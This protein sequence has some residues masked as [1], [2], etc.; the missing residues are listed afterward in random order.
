MSA[1]PSGLL[2]LKRNP[3][4]L[5]LFLSFFLAQDG[6]A[7]ICQV[8]TC[9]VCRTTLCDVCRDLPSTCV[10]PG[11][12]VGLFDQSNN[13]HTFATLKLEECSRCVSLALTKQIA[14]LNTQIID[15]IA[16]TNALLCL[17]LLLFVSSFLF[18][19]LLLSSLFYYPF[20]SLV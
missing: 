17:H 20:R 15:A 9:N 4:F 19:S 10:P 16:E 2:F 7:C 1:C 18:S 3:P 11:Q 14:P 13:S 12:A 6:C 5:F 8:V